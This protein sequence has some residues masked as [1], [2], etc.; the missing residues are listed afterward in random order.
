MLRRVR[1][2]LLELAS[3]PRGIE[4]SKAIPNAGNRVENHMSW[5]MTQRKTQL[6]MNLSVIEVRMHNVAQATSLSATEADSADDITEQNPTVL[7]AQHLRTTRQHIAQAL[8]AMREVVALSVDDAAWADQLA[9][10]EGMSSFVEDRCALFDLG[11]RSFLLPDQFQRFSTLLRQRRESVHLSR[12]ELGKRAGLS[13]RTIKNIEH[14]LVSPSRDTVVRL[15]DVTELGLTWAD[16]L[17]D[18]VKTDA[19]STSENGYN[20]YIPPGYEPLRMVQQLARMLNGPGGHIEQTFAYLEHRS[21]IAYMALGHEPAYV[22]RY[23]AIYPLAEL[24]RRVSTECGQT[25]LKVIALGPGDGNLE[26]RFVQQLLGELTKPDIELLLFDISQPLLNVAYQHALDTFGEQSQVHTLLLQGN[27]H[28]LAMYPQVSYAPAKGRRRRIYTMMGNTLANLDNEPRFFQHC[29]S[30]CQPGDFLVLDIRR[31]QAPLDASAEAI[32]KVDPVF[33]GRFP[34][35]NAEFLSTPIRTH[36]RNV[37]SCDFSYV[38]DT[39]CPIPGSYALDAVATVKTSDQTERRFSMFRF[40]SYD[41]A[42]LVQSF[43]RLGWECLFSL[44]IGP[45]EHAPLA[46]L[47]MKREEGWTGAE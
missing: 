13:D 45:Q 24:A 21:A 34:K 1:F 30:H 12:N 42:L 41:E 6:R 10:L 9:R 16:V 8:E 28:D 35:A 4:E 23:R 7:L 27:F 43:A 33:G 32:R 22:A 19:D 20:C 3:K 44:P 47:L 31:R 26:V 37:I 18:P 36:C 25:P 5:A 46:M 17:G 14:A 40:K 39:Q 15:L 38:L 11:Q 29:M 2:C